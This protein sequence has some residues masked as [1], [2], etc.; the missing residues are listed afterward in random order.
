M[1]FRYCRMMNNPTQQELQNLCQFPGLF[2]HRIKDLIKSGVLL[3]LIEFEKDT[4]FKE[5]L[6][7]LYKTSLKFF[8]SYELF[9]VY[10]SMATGKNTIARNVNSQIKKNWIRVPPSQRRV[11]V[12]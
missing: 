7:T 3:T 8:D 1:I 5:S 11:K 10:Q 4:D 9:K 2:Q 12:S 6:F